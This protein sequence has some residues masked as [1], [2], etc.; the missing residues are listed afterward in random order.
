MGG[1]AVVVKRE[2][3]M[4]RDPKKIGGSDAAAICGK[5]PHKTAYGVAM[6]LLGRVQSD[7]LEGLDHIEFGNEMEGV[8]ARFYERKNKVKLFTPQTIVHPT[9]PFLSVNIDRIREDRVDVG[10]ECKNVGIH[11]Q[12]A[13]GE[14]GTDEVPDRVNLQCQHAMMICP[15]ID[16]FHVLRCYGGNTYQMFVVPRN[17]ALI[18]A[19]FAI[20]VGFWED[21]Q[22]GVLPEPDWGHRTTKET[23]KRAFQKIEGTIE[24]KPELVKWTEAWEEASAERLRLQKLEESLK[25]HVEHLMGNVE[26]AVL[27]DGRKWRRKEV[28]RK[29]YTVEATSYIETRLLK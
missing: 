10:I 11:V 17:Q 21:L 29:E 19:L 25:N 12:E 24:A 16:T 7:E 13:W 2:G 22:R 5:D 3:A 4:V 15:F 26:V 6:R 18:D 23:I 1:N 8:L 20:E 9:I 14:P 27:P 28:S